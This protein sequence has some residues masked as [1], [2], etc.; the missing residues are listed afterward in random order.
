MTPYGRVLV[1][2]GRV[3]VIAKQYEFF[4]EVIKLFSNLLE[5]VGHIYNYSQILK[6]C[7]L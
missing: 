7:T 3:L 2:N 4:K 5:V 1:M 6:I